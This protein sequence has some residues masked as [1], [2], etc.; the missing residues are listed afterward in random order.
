MVDKVF[1]ECVKLSGRLRVRI[2]S[3]GYNNQANCQFP[4]DIR[5]EGRKY[6]CPPGDVTLSRGSAGTYFYR[7][8]K[9]NI[10]IEDAQV[11]VENVQVDRIYE[12]Q[13]ESTCCICFEEEKYIVLVPCGHYCLCSPCS[14]QVDICP[15][16]RANITNRVTRDQLQM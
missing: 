3:A 14:A 1:F 11:Q 6:S 2:I 16:C 12:D 7:I 4:R 9:V 13:E 5:A 8:K 10:Q 15:I